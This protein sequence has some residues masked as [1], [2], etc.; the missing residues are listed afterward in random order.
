[1]TRPDDLLIVLGTGVEGGGARA[2][3]DLG[4]AALAL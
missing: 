1:M 4:Y 3:Y 2:L